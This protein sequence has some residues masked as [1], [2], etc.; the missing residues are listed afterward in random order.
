MKNIFPLIGLVTALPVFANEPLQSN[1]N[2]DS[3][4]DGFRLSVKTSD[5]CIVLNNRTCDGKVQQLRFETPSGYF[6]SLEKINDQA[7]LVPYDKTYE[8]K[9]IGNLHGRIAWEEQIKGTVARF[10]KAFHPTE[11]ATL[12]IEAYVGNIS[13]AARLNAI[14]EGTA[15][16]LSFNIPAFSYQIGQHN[17]DFAGKTIST[18]G[19]HKVFSN[20]SNLKY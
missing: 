4:T 16:P 17:I 8:L 13:G 12:N 14:T 9:P 3:L 2:K 1:E 15:Y 20:Y 18:Q 5:D 10:G 6:L 7:D 19:G 11:Q